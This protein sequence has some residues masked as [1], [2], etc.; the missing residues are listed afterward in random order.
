MNTPYVT[1][2]ELAE[3]LPFS[4]RHLA[5]RVTHRRDFPAYSTTS[6]TDGANKEVTPCGLAAL[7]SSF[8]VQLLLR[9]LSDNCSL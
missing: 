3:L 5:E 4:L 2:K 9:Y 7:S 8:L 1:T 6:S